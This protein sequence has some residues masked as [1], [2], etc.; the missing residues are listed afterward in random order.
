M[1]VLA[2]IT[3]EKGAPYML[4]EV[5][6]QE[7]KSD[8]ILV[9]IHAVGVCHTDEAGRN[10]ELPFTFPVVLG[11]EGAGIIEQ[12]G[13]SVNGFQVGD[14]VC[15]TYASCG[16]CDSCIGGRPYACEAMNAINFFGVYPDGT[17]RIRFD[18]EEI[19][20]FFSQSSFATYAVVNQRSAVR[21]DRDVDFAVAAPFGCGIQTGAGIVMNSLKAEFGSSIVIAGCGTVG[22]CAVMAAKI[23]GCSRIVAVGG[24]EK[25]LEL[26]RELGATHTVNRKQVE[27]LTEAICMTGGSLDYA[28]DTSGNERMIYALLHSLTYM[29]TMSIAGGGFQLT[30]G[31]F[32]LCARTIKGVTEGDSN[33]QLFIPRLITAYQQGKFPVDRLIKKYRFDE[34]NQ[35]SQ[36]SGRGKCIK[37]VLCMEE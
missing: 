16:K 1:K 30:L 19:S 7:P 18:G 36:E 21:L 35:A 14:R 10:G 33:P 9:R 23:C 11:H 6:L 28:I 12:V 13:S 31:S 25:S 8:E 20:S 26:A 29:G 15:L 27:D 2:A 34:I 17:K 22:L 32:D 5:D 4:Q 37:A 3:K 24:N